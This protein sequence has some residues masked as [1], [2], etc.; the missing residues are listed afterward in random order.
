[1]ARINRSAA[2]AL[3]SAL[4]LVTLAGCSAQGAPRADVSASNAQTALARGDTDKAVASAEA[5]VLAE[6]RNASY[7]AM[8][9]AAYLEA[10]RFDSAAT[11]FDDAM[12]LG[13]Q[14]ARTALGYALASIARGDSR[15]AV[16]VLDDWRGEIPAADMGLALSLAGEPDRGVHVLGNALRAGENTAKVRQNLAYSYALQGNWRAARLMAAEDVSPAELDKRIAEWARMAKPEDYQKRVASLLDVPIS[17]DAG[18]PAQLALNTAPAAQQFAAQAAAATSPYAQGGE[19]PATGFV[20]M[21]PTPRT[22]EPLEDVAVGDAP[23]QP[24]PQVAVV[25]PEL[26]S[27]DSFKSA[28]NSEAPAGGSVAEIASNALAFVSSPVVQSAPTRAGVPP[29]VAP[30]QS[31]AANPTGSQLVQLGS[32]SSEAG[33]RRAWGIYTQ[34]FPELSDYEMVITQA[35]VRGKTYFRVSAGGFQVASAKS[36]CGKVKAR[37]DGC[38]AWA[39]GKPLPGAVDKG[40]RLARR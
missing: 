22:L 40:Y 15:T 31:P 16:A 21:T 26:R 37:G 17:A 4:G 30:A 7:R 5:A 3:T 18:Q 38:I 19:L 6:P 25:A 39:D 23:F 11:S 27:P 2:L 9:G 36:M 33:A 12:K 10:G 34:R 1:M 13:D 28:F 14:T 20:A 32:F 29:R 24:A 8:L 35:K